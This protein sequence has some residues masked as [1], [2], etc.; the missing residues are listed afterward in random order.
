MYTRYR[1][2]EIPIRVMLNF[3]RRHMQIKSIVSNYTETIYDGAYDKHT[4]CMFHSEIKHSFSSS[5]LSQLDLLHV[6]ILLTTVRLD[7][8][9]KTYIYVVFLFSF[10]INLE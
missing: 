3:L 7:R 4:N 5:F 9:Q 10:F 1:K 8:R 2:P 6:K